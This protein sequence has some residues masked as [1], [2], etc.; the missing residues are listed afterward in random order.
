[1]Q[2][3]EKYFILTDVLFDCVSVHFGES[4]AGPW[5]QRKGLHV[6]YEHA[7]IGYGPGQNCRYFPFED[8]AAS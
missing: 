2:S 4:K 7:T 3:H 6:F 1:M 8:T 5:V